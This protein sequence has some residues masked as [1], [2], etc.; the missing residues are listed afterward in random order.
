VEEGWDDA[1]EASYGDEGIMPAGLSA[2]VGNVA[3][4]FLLRGSISSRRR[5]VPLVCCVCRGDVWM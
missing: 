5:D 1:G 2:D 4:R 3:T